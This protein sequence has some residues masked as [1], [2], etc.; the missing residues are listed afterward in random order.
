MRTL[1]ISP[2]ACSFAAHVL[3]HELDLPIQVERVTLRTPESPIWRI[4]P[5]G[6][7]PALQLD[8]GTLLSENV[9]ILPFLADLRPGTPLFAPEGSVERA[10]IQSWIG[11]LASEVHAAALRPLNRPERYSADSAAHP[12]IRAQAR[13]QL[14]KAVEHIDRHLAGRQWLV[15][16]RFTIAD[17]YL[18][19]FAGWIGRIGE[20]FDQLRELA[21]FREAYR[22]RPAV[23][24]AAA[25]EGL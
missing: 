6:R 3:V 1:Y 15:G 2:G 20:E 17:A 19:V 24:R 5:L 13:V 18:G 4:N 11:Y 25:A 23:Q 16:E 7:V 21:R 14:F 22:A 10:Q 12:G 8:D 9:A